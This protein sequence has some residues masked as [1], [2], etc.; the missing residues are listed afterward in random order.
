M[1]TH[2]NVCF[3]GRTSATL[4]AMTPQDVVCGVLPTTYVFGLCS[5]MVAAIFAGAPVRLVPRFDVMAVCDGLRDGVT[6]FSALPQVHAQLMAHAR[7]DAMRELGSK[8]LRCV[9]SGAASLDPACKR[10]AEAFCGVA[11]QNGSEMT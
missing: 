3:G 2:G 7:T 11:L 6:L 1:L 5:V 10:E 4:H 9:S 8:T